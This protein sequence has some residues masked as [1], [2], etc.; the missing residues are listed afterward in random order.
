MLISK[1]P[2]RGDY[3]PFHFDALSTHQSL[4]LL[5]MSKKKC[6]GVKCK[7]K[8]QEISANLKHDLPKVIF[9]INTNLI[10]KHSRS[11]MCTPTNR[12]RFSL[13][14]LVLISV[15]VSLGL[16]PTVQMEESI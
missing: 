6:N 15:E 13:T 16:T 10:S 14:P 4:F 9:W 8:L 7:E 3:P 2:M 5:L 12:C 11:T 1:G